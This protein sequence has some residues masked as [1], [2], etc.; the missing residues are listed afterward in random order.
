MRL[1]QKIIWRLCCCCCLFLIFILWVA[2]LCKSLQNPNAEKIQLSCYPRDSLD[3]SCHVFTINLECMC[4]SFSF[5]QVEALFILELHPRVK[6]LKKGNR[7]ALGIFF[8]CCNNNLSPSV[9]RAPVEES[10]CSHNNIQGA[11]KHGAFRGLY[12]SSFR[13]SLNN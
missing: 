13:L 6:K 11:G 1:L 12:L 8:S 7:T 2:D 10:R 9:S 5:L 3:W 4:L